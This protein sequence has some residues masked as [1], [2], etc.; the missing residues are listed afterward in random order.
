[1]KNFLNNNNIYKSCFYYQKIQNLFYIL[2]KL[3][4]KLKNPEKYILK[5]IGKALMIEKKI[6][7]IAKPPETGKVSSHSNC[8]LIIISGNCWLTRNK[9]LLCAVSFSRPPCTVDLL[10][11]PKISN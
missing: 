10:P 7:K 2:I 1:L 8:P 3:K 4:R 5:N 11:E 9:V 6:V